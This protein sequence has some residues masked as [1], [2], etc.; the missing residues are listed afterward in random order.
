ME[1]LK[2]S[3]YQVF[4]NSDEIVADKTDV[5]YESDNKNMYIDP[6][7]SSNLLYKLSPDTYVNMAS[8]SW[9]GQHDWYSFGN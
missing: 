1:V 2:K 8:A 5:Y 7:W 4:A 3:F 9:Y 6:F